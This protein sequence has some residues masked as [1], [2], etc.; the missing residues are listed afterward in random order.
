MKALRYFF[1]ASLLV[2]TA[3]ESKTP[4]L[5]KRWEKTPVA[6]EGVQAPAAALSEG[7]LVRAG[8]LEVRMLECGFY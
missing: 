6:P 4:S 8:M 2:G 7:D 3:A 1:L 5:F